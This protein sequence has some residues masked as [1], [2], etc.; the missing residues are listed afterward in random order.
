MP[1]WRMAYAATGPGLSSVIEEMTRLQQYTF[2]CA[3]TPFQR[4]AITALNYDVS[5]FVAA[6]RRKRDRIYDGLKD[7][8]ELVRP[9][10]AFYAF[11]RAP[12]DNGTAFVEKAA[13]NNVLII[14]GGVFS[15]RDTHFRISY[16]ASDEK[17]KRGV[18]ILCEIA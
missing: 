2:V 9:A 16:A 14:P 5:E 7:K 3:P 15:E 4:A 10:G 8:F 17:I 6:Y 12:G 13:K 11:V 18:E 1:G